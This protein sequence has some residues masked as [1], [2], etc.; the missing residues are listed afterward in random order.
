MTTKRQLVEEELLRTATEC[1]T[2]RGYNETKLD[3]IV[4]HVGI[5]R[6]TFYTY[7]E[8]KAALLTAIF[9]RSLKS[10][11]ATLEE[12]LARP[13][14]RPEKIRQVMAHQIAAITTD[15][16]L[17]LLFRQEAN[18]PPE[19]VR[20]VETMQQEIDLLIEDE[21]RS[22]I[23]RGEIIDE[24]PRLLMQAFSGMC[25]WLYRW[26]QPGGEITPEEI[27]RVFSRLLESGGLTPETRPDSGGIVRALQH[28]GTQLD[29]VRQELT[30]V[31]QRLCPR[32][33]PPDSDA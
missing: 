11:R 9:T 15:Q 20:V 14:S 16:S 28:V 12:I 3:D 7:F 6:V 18:L 10:H 31:S 22:G 30:T 21:I 24:N 33:D 23:Q 27:V 1:F 5:S 8:S 29:E 25:N 19:T 2:Q 13:L 4:A 26:Y 32:T 17:C